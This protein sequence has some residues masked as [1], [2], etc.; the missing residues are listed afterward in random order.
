MK[1]KTALVCGLLAVIL[2]L[3]FTACP[4][5]NDD[6]GGVKTAGLEAALKNAHNAK[7]G[8][9]EATAASEVATGVFWVTATEMKAL[10]DAIEEAE[11]AKDNS[12]TQAEVDAAKAKLEGALAAFNTAKQQGNA[13]AITLSGTITIKN[14]GQTVPYVEIIA[15]SDGWGWEERIRLSSSEANTPWSITTKTFDVETGI[16]FRVYGFQNEFDGAQLFVI[17]VKDF[18]VYVKDKDISDINIDLANLK[19]ITLS[20]TINVSYDGKPIPS[21]SI[22]AYRDDG[23]FLGATNYLFSVGN[24]TPWSMQIEAFDEDTEI[25]F[26]IVGSNHVWEVWSE[27]DRL[28]GLWNHDFG[29]TIK[30]QNKSDIAINLISISGTINVTYDNEIV[31]YVY[32]DVIVNDEWLTN[33]M[34]T[35]PAANAK[36]T[37]VIPAL[38]TVQNNIRFNVGGGRES[39]WNRDLFGTSIRTELSIKDQ[40]VSGVALNF[41]TVSGTLTVTYDGELV[42]YVFLEVKSLG[43]DGLGGL[44]H[45]L[46]REPAANT[47]WTIVLPAFDTSPKNVG[48]AIAG[49]QEDFWDWDLFF[50]EIEKNLSI[51]DQNLLGV[52]LELGN[53]E[54]D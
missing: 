8:V 31:P 13:A 35:A 1:T 2:A 48:F 39:D 34:L 23:F 9:K 45:T 10:N 5:G 52:T 36:W 27:E 46:L 7:D 38:D 47:K 17:E 24:N 4:D 28:F 25:K 11:A 12:S 30:D 3:T 33:A 40:N 14:N 15:H 37:M 21:L 43:E 26:N 29:V 42:P 16:I 44:G 53:I 6:G 22:E 41:I 54:D 32:L 20:G 49:S 19:L 51:K 18:P 50:K